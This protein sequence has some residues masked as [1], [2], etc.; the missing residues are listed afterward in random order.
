M[1]SILNNLVKDFNHVISYSQGISNVNSKDVF[2]KWVKNKHNKEIIN[3][4]SMLEKTIMVIKL[5]DV[6]MVVETVH[7]LRLK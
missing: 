1:S 5:Q 2:K 3:Y 6:L 7:T 4:M